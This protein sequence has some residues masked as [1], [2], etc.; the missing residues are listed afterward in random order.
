MTS[1]KTDFN[2]KSVPDNLYSA[3]AATPDDYLQE[4]ENAEKESGIKALEKLTSDHLDM[5]LAIQD[6]YDV[7]DPLD[8]LSLEVKHNE[9]VD[10]QLRERISRLQDKMRTVIDSMANRIATHRYKTT[11]EALEG[12]KI[13]KTAKER[14]T[15]L[16]SSDKK[17]YVSCQS[18]KVAVDVFLEVNRRTISKL[19]ESELKNDATNARRMILGN[20]I[21]VYE[22]LDFVINYIKK[23]EI[24]GIDGIMAIYH[25]ATQKVDELLKKEQAR[26]YKA[27]SD[28][29]RPEVRE[30]V[31]ENIKSRSQAIQQISTEWDLYITAVNENKDKATQVNRNIPSLELMKEDAMGQIEVVELASLLGLVKTNLG[32]IQSSMVETLSKMELVTLSSDRVKLLLGDSLGSGTFGSSERKD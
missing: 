9:S 5:I 11:E 16:I 27:Q 25:N 23:F 1:N 31:L 22:L 14:L 18:L 24:S 26:E 28:D 32:V 20:A 10:A 2:E 21:L 17:F 12:M 3:S 6:N 7:P 29:I 15:S 4:L 8:L 19:E 30:K 13:G